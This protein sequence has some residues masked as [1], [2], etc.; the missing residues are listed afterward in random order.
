MLETKGLDEL[1]QEERDAVIE[2]KGNLGGRE[3]FRH[4]VPATRDQLGTIR[5]HKLVKHVRM[6]L[7]RFLGVWSKLLIK[8]DSGRRP[9]PSLRARRT[10]EGSLTVSLPKVVGVMLCG[11]LPCLGLSHCRAGR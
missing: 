9:V 6:I 11:F 8:Q 1:L 7:D 2:R 5:S 3:P 4:L 10:E